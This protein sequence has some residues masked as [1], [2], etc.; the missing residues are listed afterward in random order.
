MSLRNAGGVILLLAIL[1][2]P[3]ALQA[4]NAVF[5]MADRMQLKEGYVKNYHPYDPK[6]QPYF[7]LGFYP[8]DTGYSI[9]FK[10]M[11]VFD[12]IKAAIKRK[13]YKTYPNAYGRIR[14]LPV[15]RLAI[16][17]DKQAAVQ[18][19]TTSNV[20]VFRMSLAYL[21]R[22]IRFQLNALAPY[23][24]AI[25]EALLAYPRHNTQRN[26]AD[27]LDARYYR[28]DARGTLFDQAHLY[29]EDLKNGGFDMRG[30]CV[31]SQKR[32]KIQQ[33]RIDLLS[34]QDGA[35]QR[36]LT[37]VKLDYQQPVYNMD[38]SFGVRLKELLEEGFTRLRITCATT[39]NASLRYL[40]R[41]NPARKTN[42]Y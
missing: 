2:P 40:V 3:A 37:L 5:G 8:R 17:L 36:K 29:Y 27:W 13:V 15:N 4:K 25:E 1:L 34:A 21:P 42:T 39:R 26:R 31:S 10:M 24:I 33:V 7:G 35:A 20:N 19:V 41:V 6:L 28:K 11:V 18:V 38:Y 30:G 14:H 12:Y 22:E 9:G 16:L 23:T 32:G